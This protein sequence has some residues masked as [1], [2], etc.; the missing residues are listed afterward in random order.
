MYSWDPFQA[1]KVAVTY[2]EALANLRREERMNAR[3]ADGDVEMSEDDEEMMPIDGFD[4][5][6]DFR[7]M[8]E[9]ERCDQVGFSALVAGNAELDLADWGIE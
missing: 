3:D 1:R 5:L 9:L 7:L 8:A 4:G 6:G 2:R